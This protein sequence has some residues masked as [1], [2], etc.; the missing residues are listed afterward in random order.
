M[1]EWRQIGQLLF[2]AGIGLALLDSAVVCGARLL[3]EG[4]L[5]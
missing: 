1:I 4:K 5:P 2:I 3:K